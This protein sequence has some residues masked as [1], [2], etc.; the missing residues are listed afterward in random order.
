MK[1]LIRSAPPSALLLAS[2][3]SRVVLASILAPTRG[4]IGLAT[5]SAIASA[6]GLWTA[7]ALASAIGFETP[8]PK[9]ACA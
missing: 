8:A 6:I 1:S 4:A 7:V 9:L 5:A 3:V 2:V